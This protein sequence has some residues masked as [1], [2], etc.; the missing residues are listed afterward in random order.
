MQCYGDV[1][2]S[3]Q[4]RPPLGA[5]LT[6]Y[7]FIFLHL[8]VSNDILVSVDCKCVCLYL[9]IYAVTV[10]LFFLAVFSGSKFPSNMKAMQFYKQSDSITICL[11][12]DNLQRTLH[13]SNKFYVGNSFK[14]TG[15][16]QIVHR[17]PNTWHSVSSV[18]I[19]H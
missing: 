8:K 10:M 7:D 4:E 19:L 16:L 3:P 6:C 12:I 1:D 5:C 13:F 9:A 14:I 15:K 11:M 18:N 2:Y 17:V